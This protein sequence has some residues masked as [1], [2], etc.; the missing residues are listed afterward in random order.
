MATAQE[1]MDRQKAPLT[2]PSDIDASAVRDIT[3]GLNALLAD[4]FAL[5]LKTKS[6]HWQPAHP[7]CST[8]HDQCRPTFR[9]RNRSCYDLGDGWMCGVQRSLDLR[10]MVPT[11]P[12][13]VVL[14]HELHRQRR[15]GI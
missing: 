8:A 2:T 3:G 13:R 4:V 14:D 6:F 9:L 7:P 5:Y 12:Q 1:R 11:V 10:Q 15:V